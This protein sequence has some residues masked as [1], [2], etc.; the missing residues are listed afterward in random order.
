MSTDEV[1]AWL[2]CHP[3]TIYRM[4]KRKEIP[5]FHIGSDWRFSRR[6]LEQWIDE[7]QEEM[8]PSPKGRKPK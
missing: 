3:S 8:F 6:E 2:R 5:A 7:R 4:L 1:A